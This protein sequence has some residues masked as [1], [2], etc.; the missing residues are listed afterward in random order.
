MI[1]DRFDTAF[2]PFPFAEGPTV[3]LRPVA[4]LSSRGFNE[5]NGSTLFA[6]IT[7]STFATWPSDVVLRDLVVAGLNVPCR[8]RM[9]LATIPNILI[10]RRLGRL[11]PVDQLAC[12]AAFARMISG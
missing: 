2:V 1:F 4:I 6:M 5:L 3:K 7:S 11:G 12:E 10:R 8:I 9:R